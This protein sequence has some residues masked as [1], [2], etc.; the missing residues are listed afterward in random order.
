M[1]ARSGCT[2][3]MRRRAAILIAIAR[4]CGCDA[5]RNH[6]ANFIIPNAD[7]PNDPTAVDRRLPDFRRRCRA[8]RADAAC[9]ERRARPPPRYAAAMPQLPHRSIGDAAQRQAADLH[10]PGLPRRHRLQERLSELPRAEDRRA[11]AAIPGQRADR[12][13]RGKR[14]HPTMQAQ[15]QSF[16]EQDIADIAAF[17]SGLSEQRHDEDTRSPSPC[18]PPA[19][20]LA[21]CAPAAKTSRPSIRSADRAEGHSSFFRR[22]ADGPHRRRQETRDHKTRRDRPGLR[23]LPWRRRQRADRPDLSRSSAASTTTTSRTRC[24]CTATA[25]A[26]APRDLMASQAKELTDQQIADLA[27]YFGT[28]PTKLRDLHGLD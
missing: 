6:V 17:L 24:R 16:S 9:R 25:T 15:A 4:R 11:V 12:I 23:R 3:G 19:C 5:M 7:K 27:A 8:S 2:I 13:P 18:S 21:A 1:P 22:P 14:K 20:A 10:L 28:Q 26:A